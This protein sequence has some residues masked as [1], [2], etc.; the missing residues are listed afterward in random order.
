MVRYLKT[1]EPQ[2]VAS[3]SSAGR[4]HAKQPAFHV[5][6]SL[7]VMAALTASHQCGRPRVNI[8]T[9]SL[10]EHPNQVNKKGTQIRVVTEDIVD[11]VG[12]LLE[13]FQT[14][15]GNSAGRKHAIENSLSRRNGV[16]RLGGF[17]GSFP[18][19]WAASKPIPSSNIEIKW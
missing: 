17:F 18:P 3:R 7:A 10:F 16:R 12:Y 1:S 15:S 14:A 9:D 13:D 4:K 5:E 2:V 11:M 8:E 19:T 6:T